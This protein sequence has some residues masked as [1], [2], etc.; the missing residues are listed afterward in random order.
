[1]TR[2]E[3]IADAQAAKN[4]GDHELEMI[5]YRQLEAMPVETKK[6]LTTPERPPVS[7]FLSGVG[8]EVLKAGGAA[9][10]AYNAVTG[11]KN[12]MLG[13]YV[14]QG[15]EQGIKNA[16]T[17]NDANE[18]TAGDFGKFVGAAV[19]YVAMPASSVPKMMAQSALFTSGDAEERAKSA[20]ITGAL[21]YGGPLAGKALGIALK[22]IGGGLANV[23][24]GI[25]TH[26]GG[27]S[28]KQAA[29]SG[30]EGGKSL[31]AFRGNMRGDVGMDDVLQMARDD[32]KAL[33]AEKAA[34]YRSG[35]VDIKKDKSVLGFGKIDNVLKE[36]NDI[37]SYKGKVVNDSAAKYLGEIQGK[38]DDWKSLPANE[39][40]TPEG[41]DKLKQSIGAIQE[42]IP[43][44]DKTSRKVAGNIY[45]AIKDNISEQAPTYSKVMGDYSKA[46]KSLNEIEKSLSLGGKSSDDTA[47]R[48][49]Q[50]VMRNNA[51]TNYG[52]RVESALKLSEGGGDL[53]PS[54]AGQSLNA[55]TPRGIGGLIGAGNIG[56]ALSNPIAAALLPLQSPRLMGEALSLGG[57]SARGLGN[58]SEKIPSK[59]ALANVLYQMNQGE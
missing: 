12:D 56:Y 14:R 46:S 55:W 26:T 11:Q 17:A 6:E 27:E 44:E 43:F 49:L 50:S 59:A 57:A 29:K 25:G 51:N 13:D 21:G 53:M 38:I 23:V 40:H 2:E 28:L 7:R 10:D 52:N 39:Y 4:A 24:G 58:L 48:K 35:M 5:I 15:A 3:M 32:I 1:M 37:I 42:K 9:A 34:Q 22:S 20:A 33:G 18:F 16:T 41:L 47:L 36:A 45:N 8:G 31:E 19:P 54:L 30:Y